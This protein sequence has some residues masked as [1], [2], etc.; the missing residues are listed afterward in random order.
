[1]IASPDVRN[2]EGE[3]VILA[4]CTSQRT[5]EIYPNEVKLTGLDLPVDTKVQADYLF[6]VKQA[7]LREKVA[8][9]TGDQRDAFDR[10]LMISLG[11]V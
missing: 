5:D 1:V 6:T 7:R 2:R 8:E 4:G 3:N 9:L 11:L 10:A